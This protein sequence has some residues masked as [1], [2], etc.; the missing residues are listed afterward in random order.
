ML[1]CK[2]EPILLDITF[3]TQTKNLLEHASHLLVEIQLLNLLLR[4]FKRNSVLILS[5]ADNRK[6]LFTITL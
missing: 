5:F 6:L 1:P 4:K 3:T 2:L